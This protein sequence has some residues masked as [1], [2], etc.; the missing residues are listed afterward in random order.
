MHAMVPE[1]SWYQIKTILGSR[2]DSVLDYMVSG[3]V[4]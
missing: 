2:M 3:S 4:E 1:W